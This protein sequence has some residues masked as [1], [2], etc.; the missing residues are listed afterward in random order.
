MVSEVFLLNKRIQQVAIIGGGPAGSTLAI[1]LARAGIKTVI[2]DVGKRPELIVGESLIP[3]VMPIIWD[4]GVEKE[5]KEYSIL[6]PGA[7]VWMK[8]DEEASGEYTRAAGNLPPYSYHVPRDKFDET[9]LKAA[10]R[11]GAHLIRERAKLEKQTGD[12]ELKLSSESLGLARNYLDGEPD[13]IVDASGRTRVVSKILN[14]TYDEGER[15]DWALFAHLNKANL[16]D[17]G[18]VHMHR[19]EH[20]WSWRIPLHDRA[21]V[22]V[23]TDPRHLERYG[24]TLEEQFDNFIKQEPGIQKFTKD[25]TRISGVLKYNNYQLIS[26]KM[27][28]HGWALTGDAAGFLDPVFSSGVY[29][30][31][32]SGMELSSAIVEGTPK[33]FYQY[34]K[35]WINELTLWQ[36]MVDSWYNGR[37]FTLFRL[38]QDM[39]NNPVGKAIEPHM[40][41][42]L[43]QI[44]TGGAIDSRYSRNFLPFATGKLLDIMKWMGL[45]KRNPEDLVI[46]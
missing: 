16:T 28:G 17:N 45:N 39:M 6:K 34:E 43:I 15:K 1:K 19:C 30:A 18:H 44:F 2:F 29:L 33:A 32:K 25:S 10:V 13:L 4:L 41:G 46:R 24:S 42:Q 40:A 27:V 26:H 35:M 38:G 20:G 36:S 22:G 37:L 14:I 3:A 12:N 7:S 31:M 8:E 23:V 5:I 21:S 9:L 11:E